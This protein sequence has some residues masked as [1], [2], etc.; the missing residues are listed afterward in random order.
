M[1]DTKYFIGK[2]A[3]GSGR[4]LFHGILPEFA[5]RNWEKFTKYINMDSR[6]CGRDV[7]PGTSWIQ[8]RSVT[9]RVIFA[10]S[11]FAKDAGSIDLAA[12]RRIEPG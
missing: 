3:V 4:S 8:V 6:C 2:T 1:D 10:T 7:N 11:L 5:R 9:G 12:R